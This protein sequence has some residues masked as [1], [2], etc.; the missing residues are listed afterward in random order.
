MLI[1]KQARQGNIHLLDAHVVSFTLFCT[2][3]VE[4][5]PNRYIKES[6]LGPACDQQLNW[7]IPNPGFHRRL[8]GFGGQTTQFH[9]RTQNPEVWVKPGSGPLGHQKVPNMGRNTEETTYLE[10]MW[11]LVA[12]KQRLGSPESHRSGPPFWVIY[13]LQMGSIY[14]IQ[15]VWGVQNRQK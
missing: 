13:T 1:A 4:D 15:A 11:N 9:G 7:G 10:A 6:D 2:P 14:A 3:P 12:I 5:T 8:N